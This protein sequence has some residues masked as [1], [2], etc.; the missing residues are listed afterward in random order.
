MYIYTYIS[1]IVS[2]IITCIYIK[3]YISIYQIDDRTLRQLGERATKLRADAAT[4]EERAGE[5][6]RKGKSA[7]GDTAKSAKEKVVL[8]PKC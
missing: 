4:A 8:Y 2:Y 6:E 7:G 3:K 5:W 1:Y